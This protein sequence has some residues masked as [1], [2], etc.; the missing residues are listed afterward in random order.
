M[1][2]YEEFDGI[3]LPVESYGYFGGVC[4]ILLKREGLV[5]E[6]NFY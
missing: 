6:I 1:T 3:K 2:N 5:N 4:T